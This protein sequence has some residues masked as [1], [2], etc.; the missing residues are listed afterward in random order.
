MSVPAPSRRRLGVE[1][2]VLGRGQVPST[3]VAGVVV[4]LAGI[5]HAGSSYVSTDPA[6][7]SWP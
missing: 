2:G 1:A 5:A 6:E 7:N 3:G 4:N